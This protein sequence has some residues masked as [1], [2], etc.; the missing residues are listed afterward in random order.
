LAD[1]GGNPRHEDLIGAARRRE[2]TLGQRTHNTE[3]L[4]GLVPQL[5]RSR[6][7]VF[8]FHSIAWAI[9]FGGR[10]GDEHPIMFWGTVRAH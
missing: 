1:G 4:K 9:P 6:K 3:R 2:A 8:F 5:E 7:L 10:R